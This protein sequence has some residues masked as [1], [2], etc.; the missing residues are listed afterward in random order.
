MLRRP[1]RAAAALAALACGACQAASAPV[2]GPADPP[3]RRRFEVGIDGV[4]LTQSVQDHARAERATG[5]SP[6]A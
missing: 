5:I 2:V 6:P 4:Y 3:L 1:L